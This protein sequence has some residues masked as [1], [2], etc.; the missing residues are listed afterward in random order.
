MGRIVWIVIR[1]IFIIPYYV[2][3][4]AYYMKSDKKTAQDKYE[5]LRRLVNIV[6]K[7]GRVEV[8]CE[9]TENLP[10]KD[11][12]IITPNHQ[13]MYD[14]LTILETVGHPVSVVIK[15]ELQDIPFLKSIFKVMGAQA[16]DREDLRQ[17]MR[18]I[19]EVSK[20]VSEGINY[21]IFPEGTRSKEGN[22]VGTFKAGSYKIATKTKCPIVPVALI[23]AYKPFDEKGL[24]KTTVQIYYLEPVTYEQYQGMQTA[25]IAALVKERIVSKIE[26]VTGVTQNK[27]NE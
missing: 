10:Q 27:E 22:V 4:M 17:S 1:N 25:E 2:I 3:K 12:F 8:K 9:G 23:D 20:Q 7:T 19:I 21:V 14:V 24:K 11:G 6:N 13:G 5:L 18:V 15:K 26:E 16:M